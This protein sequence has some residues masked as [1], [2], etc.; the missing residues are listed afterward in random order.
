LKENV[1][2]RRK[3]KFLLCLTQIERLRLRNASI[4]SNRSMSDIVRGGVEREIHHIYE[5][6]K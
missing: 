3:Y 2:Q 1:E 4:K 6:G 5:G